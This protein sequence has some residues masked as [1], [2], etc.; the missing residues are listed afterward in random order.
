MTKYKWPQN[1]PDASYRSRNINQ[2]ITSNNDHEIMRK[3]LILILSQKLYCWSIKTTA[4]A[5]MPHLVW[6]RWD[7]PLWECPLDLFLS[8][9]LK[10]R[11]QRRRTGSLVCLIIWPKSQGISLY[12]FFRMA[13]SIKWYGTMIK[14]RQKSLLIKQWGQ[15]DYLKNPLKRAARFEIVR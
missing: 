13:F 11:L 5:E 7:W 2:E 4:L 9:A 15:R 6:A 3:W 12:T 1:D 14:N 10:F 8:A